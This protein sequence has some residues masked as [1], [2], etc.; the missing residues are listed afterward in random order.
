MESANFHFVSIRKTTQALKLPSEAS[1]RFGR[2]V[3]PA[4]A[5]PAVTRATALM[6]ALAGGKI[7]RGVADC[8][9]APQVSPVVTL[10]VA[11]ARRILGM[12]VP[13]EDMARILKA[14]DFGCEPAGEAA[15]RVTAPAHRLD[16]GEGIIGVHDL[17]EEVARV[18]GY[19]RIPVTDMAD[20]LPP[21][22]DNAAVD[23]EER[24]RD[25]LIVAGLQE[26]ITYRLTTPER[27]TALGFPPAEPSGRHIRLANP[28]S[29]DRVVLRQTLLAGLLEAVARN[30][31]VRDRLWFFEIGPVYLPAR[32]GTSGGIAPSR[33]RHRRSGHPGIVARPG[34]AARGLFHA[35]R[36][37]R[38]PLAVSTSG[39][40]F[41]PVDHP[42]FA[43]GRAARLT[44]R[45]GGAGIAR[46]DSP[47]SARP[48]DLPAASVCLAEFDLEA[49]F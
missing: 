35:Q 46:G 49:L 30:A 4:I 24:L 29:A 32:E 40:R 9:P 42:T 20:Q 34:S 19:D 23:W 13:R 1:A 3:P 22:R 12:E 8:Y 11:D 18:F 21:Q 16:V 14:L 5:V 10:D 37:G 44:R 43:P 36:R 15:L 7:A 39:A 45:K 48:F 41:H 38:I 17:L 33:S 6:Q 27:E 28:I 31:R 47:G 25:L 26:I 2:G